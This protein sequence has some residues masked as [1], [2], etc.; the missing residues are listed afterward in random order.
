MHADVPPAADTRRAL[1]KAVS[2]AVI[3]MLVIYG[4][5]RSPLSVY[6]DPEN[7]EPWHDLVGDAGAWAK[8]LFIAVG[9]VI[10]SVGVP[11]TVVSLAGGMLF[12]IAMGLVTA[13]AATM[14]SA[15]LTFYVGRWAGHRYVRRRFGERIG[16]VRRMMRQHG[17]V[18]MILIRQLP[19]TALASNLLC[20]VSGVRAR[21]YFL[22]SLIGLLPGAI[23]FVVFGAGVR[24]DFGL[25]ATAAS[26]LLVAVTF[27]ALWLVNRTPWLQ[28][29][30]EMLKKEGRV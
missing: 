8:P 16:E 29:L 5:R 24:R 6:L 26:L 14:L 12:G 17:V 21:H 15:M 2:M 13:M 10:I 11:R 25:R 18:A 27:G 20:S 28:P 30:R 7:L 9:M 3:L 23:I 1:L 22:G 19:I 4:V